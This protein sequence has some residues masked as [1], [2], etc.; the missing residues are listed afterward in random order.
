MVDCLNF[1][2]E[3]KHKVVQNKEKRGR[4]KEAGSSGKLV[5]SCKWMLKIEERI[6]HETVEY[7]RSNGPHSF[8]V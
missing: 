4:K 6:G 7:P 1:L 2:F 3:V 5:K 8:P